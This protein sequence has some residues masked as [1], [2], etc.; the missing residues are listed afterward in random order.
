MKK[1]KQSNP[2]LIQDISFIFLVGCL[3]WGMYGLI[4]YNL[5]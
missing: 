2:Y 1:T 5:I 4:I 3:F